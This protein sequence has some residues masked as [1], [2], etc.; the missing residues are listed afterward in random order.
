MIELEVTGLK[1]ATKFLDDMQAELS[2]DKGTL[3]KD[4]GKILHD[5]IDT[6]FS[7]EG[8]P[9]WRQR[10]TGGDWPVLDKTGTMKDDALMSTRTW[11]HDGHEHDLDIETPDYGD[12]HQNTGCLTRGKKVFRPFATLK[13]AGQRLVEK[14]IKKV[15]D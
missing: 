7:V 12:I 5:E 8:R 14:R 9:K 10:V 6:N 2:G 13:A 1:A 15:G 11:K 4:I 3:Y